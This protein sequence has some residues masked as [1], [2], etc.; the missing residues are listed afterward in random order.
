MVS[1]VKAVAGRPARNVAGQ[2][3]R[4]LAAKESGKRGYERAARLLAEIAHGVRPG[5]EIALAKNGRKA[6]LVDRFEEKD[7]VWTPCAA[8]RWELKI[9]EP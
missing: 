9:I 1:R 8:R 6:V 5:Q 3:K 2:V 7:I 4:Y